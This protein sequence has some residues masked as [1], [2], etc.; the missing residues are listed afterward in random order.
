MVNELYNRL[1]ENL[2]NEDDSALI[3][4]DQSKAYEIVDHQ[5]LLRKLDII[6]FSTPAVELM[7]S[8]LSQRKQFVQIHATKSESLLTGPQSVVQGSSISCVLFLIFVLDLPNIFHDSNH[9]PE[10]S[11]KCKNPSAK[12]FVDDIG[13]IIT[14][15]KEDDSVSL[16]DKISQ[17]M[18]KVSEYT[19]AN[20]L[21]LNQD[22]T[23]IMLVT[24]NQK[25]KSDFEINLGEKNFETPKN[26][27][28]FRES[29]VRRFVL[30]S[31]RE[32]RINPSSTEQSQDVKNGGKVYGPSF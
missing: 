13:I 2:A 8:F 30:G 11:S 26:C 32:K 6:G 4:L 21:Q 17:T 31:P 27:Q 22:K 28:S 23:L 24:K 12:T 20:R 25:L 15:H 14:K 7:K 29:I 10:E 16:K 19:R 5:I 18:Q 3:C 9:S 1:Q